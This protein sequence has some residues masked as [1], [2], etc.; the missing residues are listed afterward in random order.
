M[1]P[2]PSATASASSSASTYPH[3][4][5]STAPP[6]KTRGKAGPIGKAAVWGI[7]H[8]SVR[9]CTV[10]ECRHC[11]ISECGPSPIS[12][13][14]GRIH[15]PGYRVACA[16]PGRS[17]CHWAHTHRTGSISPRHLNHLLSAFYL[18]MITLYV[19]YEASAFSGV[20]SKRIASRSHTALIALDAGP[21]E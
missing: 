18:S 12:I 3:P 21:S 4:P 8:R 1:L 15:I 10:S 17:T 16:I 6:Q 14:R 2:P 5:A 9:H 11:T 20:S 13:S 19:C 7:T